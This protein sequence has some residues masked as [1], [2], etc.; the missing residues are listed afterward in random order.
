MVSRKDLS[1]ENRQVDSDDDLA[2]MLNAKVKVENTYSHQNS[3]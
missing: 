3:H 2:F 1:R